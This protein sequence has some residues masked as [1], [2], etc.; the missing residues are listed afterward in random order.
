MV[1]EGLGFVCSTLWL[2]GSPDLSLSLRKTPK[3]AQKMA[4]CERTSTGTF[5]VSGHPSMSSA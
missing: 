1:P 5:P 4:E 3:G 2:Q